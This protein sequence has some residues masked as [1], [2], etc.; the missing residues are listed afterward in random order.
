MVASLSRSILDDLLETVGSEADTIGG[1]EL[2]L[3]FDPVKTKGV[4]EAL[5]HV[6]HQQDTKGDTSKDTVANEGSKPVDV[7]SRKH[8]LLPKHSGELG[9]S[10]RQGPETKVRS[11]VGNHT[12]HELNRFDGLVNDDLSKS[13][14]F[15]I[16]FATMLLLSTSSWC[17]MG[18]CCLPGQ[19]VRLGKEKNR[20]R[21]KGDQE[22]TFWIPGLSA[23]M[24]SSTLPGWRAML[25]R[26]VIR[27]GGW[28]PSPDPP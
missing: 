6:H 10:K 5:E 23:Y 7:Q 18:A 25:I 27:L 16:V 3:E 28:Q 20:N 24:G 15:V 26:V 12:K 4:Q 11:R 1:K 19:K 17:S 21:R 14:I 13:V 22:K 2:V 8:G 9:V